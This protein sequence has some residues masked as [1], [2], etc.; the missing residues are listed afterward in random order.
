MPKVVGSIVVFNQKI[1]VIRRTIETFLASAP[2]AEVYIWDNSKTDLISQDLKRIF[3][4]HVHY[5]KSPENSGYGRGNN[6]VFDQLSY[7]F[8]YFCILN[9][10]LEIPQATIP[11]L[12]SYL[13]EH[14][15][16]GLI[17]G[18]VQGDEGKVHEV[19]KL[20]P[21][22]S[23]YLKTILYRLLKKPMQEQTLVADK[24]AQ[25]AP[26]RLPILSG[27]FLFFKQSHYKELNGFD[28]RFFLYFEDYDLTL[29]SFMMNKSIVLPDAKIIHKWAR[30]SHRRWKLFFAHMKSGMQFYAKWGF[31]NKFP[32][33][34]N[35][36]AT[37]P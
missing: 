19:H 25:G 29:R 27:C 37:Q 18:T 34:V 11:Q 2:S 28:D 33:Q 13:E 32:S 17:S 35:A 5:L 4:S 7:D 6:S 1:P 12:I 36:K 9:P 15:Q 30:E 21:S 26:Y 16:L 10:D 3:P 14:P 8:D 20:L 24:V 22:F 31:S 23:H